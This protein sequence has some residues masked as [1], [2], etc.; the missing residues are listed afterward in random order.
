MA[1]SIEPALDTNVLSHEW[2]IRCADSK[3]HH[4]NGN[5]SSITHYDAV[6][7]RQIHQR[8][9]AIMTSMKIAFQVTLGI[10]GG[11]QV[12][13]VRRVIDF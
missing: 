5:H 1:K 3:Y 11:V 10:G 13:S 8:G 6:T 9:S 4:S 12:G 7:L 2:R